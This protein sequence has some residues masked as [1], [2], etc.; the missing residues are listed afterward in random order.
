[1][2]FIYIT[3]KIDNKSIQA[4]LFLKEV[5]I[6]IKNSNVSIVSIGDIKINEKL[7]YFLESNGFLFDL[8]FDFSKMSIKEVYDTIQKS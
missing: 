2:G 1:L 5:N 6:Q 8:D 4:P 7:T 3:L